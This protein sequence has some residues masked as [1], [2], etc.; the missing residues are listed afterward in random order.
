MKKKLAVFSLLIFGSP[1]CGI[2]FC[3]AS[4]YRHLSVEL[5]LCSL[6][7]FGRGVQN[8]NVIPRLTWQKDTLRNTRKVVEIS[9]GLRPASQPTLNCGQINGIMH[10]VC[11]YPS[12]SPANDPHRLISL[13]LLYRLPQSTAQLRIS[14]TFSRSFP[15]RILI[16]SLRSRCSLH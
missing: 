5:L 15:K 14:Q 10:I 4:P 6:I 9:S 1:L 13:H 7:K 2:L 11:I 12:G 3:S 8:E 16:N